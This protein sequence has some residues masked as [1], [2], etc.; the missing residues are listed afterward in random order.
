MVEDGSRGI[1]P[2]DLDQVRGANTTLELVRVF[3][4]FDKNI[5]PDQSD[6]GGMVKYQ[7]DPLR[8]LPDISMTVIKLMRL[9][10]WA[11]DTDRKVTETANIDKPVSRTALEEMVSSLSKLG[12]FD[13]L[14]ISDSYSLI[15]PYIYP[16]DHRSILAERPIDWEGYCILQPIFGLDE[17][18]ILRNERYRPRPRFSLYDLP[19]LLDLI[20]SA[21]RD[22][23]EVQE[24]S[25]KFPVKEEKHYLAPTIV[26]GVTARIGYRSSMEPQLTLALIAS[27]AFLASMRPIPDSI[28]KKYDLGY[29]EDLVIYGRDSRYE[30][31]TEEAMKRRRISMQEGLYSSTTFSESERNDPYGSQISAAREAR[32]KFR[33]SESEWANKFPHKGLIPPWIWSDIY[34]RR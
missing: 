29:I 17:D 27:P 9:Q 28:I 33:G 11:R 18:S 7:W 34:H 32:K 15:S 26:E 14:R 21:I 8:K 23:G 19:S 2:L 12:T 3:E 10:R 30:K 31:E 6:Y 20:S 5:S 1:S 22:K 4:E 13:P 24:A 25:V 16:W